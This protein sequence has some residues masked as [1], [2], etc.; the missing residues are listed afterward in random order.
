MARL[1]HGHA[2][3]HLNHQQSKRSHLESIMD[4]LPNVSRRDNTCGNDDK[5]AQCAKPAESNSITIPVVLAVV[6]VYPSKM[7][8]HYG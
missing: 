1:H 5:A 7:M 3:F 4:H 8:L 2:A 6:Y